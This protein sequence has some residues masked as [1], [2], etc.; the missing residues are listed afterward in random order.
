ML[1]IRT[2]AALTCGLAVAALG[3]TSS[4]NAQPAAPLAAAA[5]LTTFSVHV[6][7]DST[8]EGDEP[9]LKVKTVF[10]EAPGAM[11]NGSTA[12]VNET[13]H[14]GDVVQAWDADDPDGDDF[15]GSATI[16]AIASGKLSFVGDG[17]NYSA[18]YRSGAC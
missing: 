15:I 13:V 14:V 2:T 10:W 9:Y 12:A 18:Q 7:E 1:R 6:S 3:M 16:R 4:A 17:A 8:W 11:D 5:C